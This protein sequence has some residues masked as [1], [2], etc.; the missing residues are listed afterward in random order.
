MVTVLP[1]PA[2]CN[3]TPDLTAKLFRGLADVSR[4]AIVAGLRGGERCVSDLVEATGLGHTN[5]PGHL[6]CL[7][8]CLERG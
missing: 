2:D 4:L 1:P 8:G 7:R 3:A 5:V 6:T